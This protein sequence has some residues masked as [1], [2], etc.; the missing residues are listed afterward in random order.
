VAKLKERTSVSKRA[1]RKLDLN[2]FDVRKLN[3]LEVKEN[4]QVETSNRFAV[5]ENLDES[6][7]I[8][9]SWECTREKK[10]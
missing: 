2:R 4:Y 5:L 1:R 3:D 8:N 6:S 7:N 10:S 9:S